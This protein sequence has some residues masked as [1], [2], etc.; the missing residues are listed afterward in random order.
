M[1]PLSLDE[2]VGE[3]NPVRI[4]D[5]FISHFDFV[6]LGIAHAIPAGEGRPSFAPADLMKRYLYGYLNRIR[7]CLGF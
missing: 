3:D 6:K 7:S 5:L 2:L 1:F 4:V